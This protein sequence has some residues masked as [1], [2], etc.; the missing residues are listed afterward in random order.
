M[1]ASRALRFCSGDVQGAAAF[2]LQQRQQAAERQ[3][4]DK[5]RR[6][7]RKGAPPQA[8]YPVQCAAE[9]S[10]YLQEAVLVCMT[11]RQHKTAL[12]LTFRVV[13]AAAE[14]ELLGRTAVSKK[15]VDVDC[16]ARLEALGFDRALAV[17]ALLQ[18][19]H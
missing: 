18:V 15:P 13:A 16:L 2:L 12:A 8:R 5:R 19:W 3:Q 7:I 10:P 6:A 14:V 11:W 9:C 1:Q 4:A 17:Q